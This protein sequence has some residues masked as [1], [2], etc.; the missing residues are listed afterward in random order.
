MNLFVYTDGACS[1]N[2][3]AGAVGGWAY[4][5]VNDNDELVA[6]GHSQPQEGTTNQQMEIMAVIEGLRAVANIPHF[7]ATVYSDSAYCM[8]AI[9]DRWIEKWR[10][11]G[12]L[13][14]KNEPVKNQELWQTLYALYAGN[15]ALN[16][17]KVKG[18]ATDKWNNFVDVMAVNAREGRYNF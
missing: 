9:N 17:V 14:S 11:N 16:F 18:H 7:S 12:W 2:G 10:V 8:N 4:A 3:Y 1:K 6:S 13:T 15:S 5:I